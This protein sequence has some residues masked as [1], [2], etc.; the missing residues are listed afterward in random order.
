[1][2]S[3]CRGVCS[4]LGLRG[5]SP[6]RGLEQ[7]PGRGGGAGGGGL[8]WYG[9]G[10]PPTPTPHTG[11]MFRFGFA[12]V[13]FCCTSSS[14]LTRAHVFSLAT[15]P[16]VW[17]GSIPHPRERKP[18]EAGA[19]PQHSAPRCSGLCSTRPARRAPQTSVRVE[20]NHGVNTF[21]S[22]GDVP[23]MITS[24]VRRSLHKTD[25]NPQA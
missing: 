6:G 24:Q 21:P 16:P 5:W 1:M 10:R 20:E 3:Q 22:W 17:G 19:E 15:N 12:S 9:V 13:G 23:S 4:R 11:D 7:P 8:W 18:S 25:K 2:W 14:T